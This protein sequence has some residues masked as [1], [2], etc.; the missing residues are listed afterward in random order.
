MTSKI[1]MSCF[2]NVWSKKREIGERK[3][4]LHDDD[5]NNVKIGYRPT[6]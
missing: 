6:L 5:N 1:K 4:L 2:I 3:N